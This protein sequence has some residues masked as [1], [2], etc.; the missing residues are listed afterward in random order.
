[1]DEDTRRWYVSGLRR[2][3]N[4]HSLE[5]IDDATD[6]EIL[7]AIQESSENQAVQRRASGQI[8][9]F[10]T[11]PPSV[12]ELSARLD[13]LLTEAAEDEEDETQRALKELRV[14]LD[15]EAPE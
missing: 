4:L 6:D 5:D 7:A 3:P 10:K 9:E 12:E 11:L 13:K 2:R 14:I 15:G 8:G 1:M